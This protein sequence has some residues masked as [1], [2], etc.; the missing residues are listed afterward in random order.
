MEMSLLLLIGYAFSI[1]PLL[2][3][4]PFITARHEDFKF[5]EGNVFTCAVCLWEGGVCP[6]GEY[7]RGWVLT[8][9]SRH[10]IQWDTVDKR[11]VRILMECFLV[12]LNFLLSR[13]ATTLSVTQYIQ[14]MFSKARPTSD[15]KRPNDFSEYMFTAN[16]QTER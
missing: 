13:S 6:G 10:G 12:S 2:R 7:A 3:L 15:C 8:Q 9:P 16:T 5:R 1:T 4:I 11:A 14:K